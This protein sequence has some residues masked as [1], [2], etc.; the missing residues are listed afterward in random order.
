MPM[1]GSIRKAGRP[2]V[3]HVR[4]QETRAQQ[5]AMWQLQQARLNRGWPGQV[6]CSVHDTKTPRL[7]GS[8]GDLI[9]CR[10]SVVGPR[11]AKTYGST[12]HVSPLLN[13]FSRSPSPSVSLA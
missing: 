11:E 10:R 3:G 9:R 1:D 4:G 7:P 6:S 13:S 2:S 12:T 5:V 8:R